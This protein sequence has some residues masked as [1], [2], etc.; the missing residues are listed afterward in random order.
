MDITWIG[1]AAFR[2][3]SGQ[4]ELFMDPFGPSL[5]LTVPSALANA[6]VVTLSS[7]TPNHGAVET[8]THDPPPTVLTEPG[9]YEVAGL[10]I[11]GIRTRL[12]PDD[13]EEP[14]WNTIFTVELEGLLVCHLGNPGAR[15]SDRQIE[16]LSSPQVLILPV[17]SRD[18]LSSLDAVDLV[19]TISPKLV[20]PM[21]YAHEGNKTDLGDLR[22]FTQEVGLARP[23]PQSRL[24]VTR[25]SLPE[26]PSLAI[27][28]PAATAG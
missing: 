2:I 11:K 17:G 10:N 12:G 18:G 8:I 24:T 7:A 21:M 4:T 19:N 25:A 20:I 27:L 26:E 28:V 16:E 15:L 3:R 23:E 22:P 13:D 9:E 6:A 1:H 5:G 14:A